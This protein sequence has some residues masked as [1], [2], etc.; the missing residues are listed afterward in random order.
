MDQDAQEVKCHG[1]TS[2]PAGGAFFGLINCLGVGL[3]NGSLMVP[4]Q[5]FQQGCD[6]IGIGA[7]EGD[8]LA[9]LAFLPSLALGILA[10][11]PVFFALHFR[12]VLLAGR[13]P[14]FHFSA[15]ALP[16]FLTGMFWGMGNFDAMFATVYLGQTIGY[17]LTQC[18]LILNG[19]WGILYYKE[20]QGAQPIGLF[21][22]ASII[23][24]VGAA[25]DGMYG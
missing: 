17:P 8:I 15:V 3:F 2:G 18:C 20:I 19:L 10:V 9:P 13:L 23:I 12:R 16:G 6:A 22:L 4:M 1:S 11:L 5:C 25:L 7:Y 21:V 24:I 14:N